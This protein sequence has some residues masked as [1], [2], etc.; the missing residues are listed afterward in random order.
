MILKNVITV[1]AIYLLLS[2]CSTIPIKEKIISIEGNEGVVIGNIEINTYKEDVYFPVSLD[3]V[4]WKIEVVEVKK[5]PSFME[6]KFPKRFTLGYIKPNIGPTTF[7]RKLQDGVYYISS[8]KQMSP[9]EIVFFPRV[10]FKVFAGK[11]T[12]IGD[13]SLSIPEKANMVKR[14]LIKEVNV[15]ASVYDNFESTEI[16]WQ[17][18]KVSTQIDELEK[19]LMRVL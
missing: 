15:T 12:Y 4:K 3:K 7:Q 1:C 5:E 17:Q 9:P 19:S 2:G 6:R 14:I 16:S 8:V 18:E 13:L 11:A 10:I